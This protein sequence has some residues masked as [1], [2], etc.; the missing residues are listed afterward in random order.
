MQTNNEQ[1]I[2]LTTEEITVKTKPSNSTYGIISKIAYLAGVPKRIFENP[3]EPPQMDCY[4]KLNADKNARIIRNL[5]RLR[6]AIELH[7]GHINREMHYYLKN[8]HDFPNEI[9]LDS[10]EQLKS[11]GIEIWKANHK[12]EQYI[13]DINTHILNRISN[14]K[15]LFPLWLKWD[16]V[17]ALFIMPNGRTAEGIRAAANEY[18]ANKQNYPYQVYMNW[19]SND[20][21]I[22]YNDEKFVTLLYTAN[23]DHFTDMSKVTDAKPSSKNMVYDFLSN[24]ERTAILVDCENVDPLRL[25]ATL[26]NLDQNALLNKITKI[27]LCDDVNTSS[28]WEMFDQHTDIP[29]E[30]MLISRVTANKSIVDQA[31]SSLATKEYLENKTDS[32]ILFGS[33]S[34]YW[35]LFRVLPEAKYLLMVEYGKFGHDHKIALQEAGIPYCY[36]SNFCTGNSEELKVNALLSEIQK[37][38]DQALNLNIHAVVNKAFHE[39]FVRM[40]P[41][42]KSQFF[43]R[44]IKGMRLNIAQ[45]GNLSI[46]MGC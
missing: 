44:Y 24:S 39:T 38:L 21:N 32:I 31:L 29:V 33:D 41:A 37:E 25:Y 7:Y 45:D 34:D 14:C 22:L 13:I 10:L 5:C 3:N 17:K 8:L 16:Y 28:A 4:E 20:G 30:Y 11:D 9:P 2:N 23:H 1:N 12:L 35:G 27:I 15:N 43:N 6:T 40:S 19:H 26:N 18:Y 46:V 36:I 42:E